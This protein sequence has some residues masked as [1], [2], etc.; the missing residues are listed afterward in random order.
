LFSLISRES[1]RFDCIVVGGGLVGM[2]TAR[3]LH[4]ADMRVL[5]LERGQLGREASWAGGGILSP[6]YPWHH[7][8]AVNRMAAISQRAYRQLASDLKEE[9]GIDPEWIQSGMLVL[10]AEEQDTAQRW[11]ADHNVSFEYLRLGEI[12][13]REPALTRSFDDGFWLPSIAQIRS[14]RLVKALRASL[15]KP[16]IEAREHSEVQRLRVQAG[17]VTGV[18]T[19]QGKL[20]TDRVLITAGAWSARLI[21]SDYAPIQVEPVRG[22]IV[23]LRAPPG[24]VR[25]IVLYRGDYLIPRSDGRVLVG[26]TLENAG[27]NK[28]TTSQARNDLRTK[29][30]EWVPALSKSQVEHHWSGLRPGSPAGIPYVGEHP[31]IRGLYFNTGHFRCGVVLAP[32]SAQLATDLMLGRTPE[33]SPT[34]YAVDAVR[35]H[36]STS[37]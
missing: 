29:A 24:I 16:R 9:T 12:H 8:A 5:L 28:A 32:A 13:Q 14:P 7:P 37:P 25:G 18:E 33:L 31:H 23:L 6:L 36:A 19:A 26:S 22:Q 11:C 21:P 17:T 2:L 35:P 20:D 3:R 27:F 1:A 34:P 10:D 4:E 15:D 30:I